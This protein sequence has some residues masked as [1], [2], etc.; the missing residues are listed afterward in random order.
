MINMKAYFLKEA[1]KIL[2]RRKLIRLVWSLLT[3]GKSMY[4]DSHAHLTDESVKDHL[5][6]MLVRAQE[7]GVEKVVNICTGQASLE[8]GLILAKKYPW[9]YNAAATTPHDVEKEGESFFPIVRR[10]AQEKKLI[11]IGE[12]GLDYH[13][14]HSNR[15]VQKK[16]LLKYFE[17][18]QEVGLPLIFHC[19]EAF[20][21]L[22][23]M[24]D[25]CYKNCPAVLHCFTGT[26]EEAQGCLDR[27]W[28]ISFSGIVSFKKS[29]KL[30]EVAAY[31]PLD[32][33]LIETDT[34]YL[35]PQSCRGKTNE[36]SYI[37]ETAQ[38]LAQIKNIS[39]S[40]LGKQTFMN[41]SQFFSF[42]KGV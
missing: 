31:V 37:L 23:E 29:E 15:E 41:A 22:F 14:E 3:L 9:I 33:M 13:Y 42:P 4:I 11:A 28:L 39:T 26:I 12:T 24:A 36:P 5:E 25:M 19:R 27:G 21:D 2:A 16:F 32:K 34:P 38:V 6:E 35:A 1:F 7:K 17:L 40:E 20:A 10:C 18:A 8:E 30:R